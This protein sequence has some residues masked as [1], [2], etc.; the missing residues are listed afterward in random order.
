MGTREKVTINIDVTEVNRIAVE[1]KSF[2]LYY[3]TSII[4]RYSS[5]K[6][7]YWNSS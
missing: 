1:F 3:V 7:Y 4:F 5:Y 2:L 6:L